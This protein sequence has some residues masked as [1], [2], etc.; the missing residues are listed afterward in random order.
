M[1]TQKTAPEGQNN[2]HGDGA[3]ANSDKELSHNRY[4]QR[5]GRK[6]RDTRERIV[7]A[8]ASLIDD[9]EAGA[10][11]LSAVA[12]EAGVGMTSIYN[13]FRDFTE[14][15]LALL[16]PVTVSAEEGHLKKLRESWP[17]DELD[18]HCIEFVR[19]YYEFWRKH[20]RLL[21]LRNSLADVQD[22]RMM[23]QRVATATP[24]IMLLRRQ[25]G[26]QSDDRG[27]PA[28]SMATSLYIGLERA[29]TVATDYELEKAFPSEFV[30][31]VES[32]ISSQSRLFALAIRDQRR[33]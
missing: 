23:K 21:H 32:L 28:L 33:A 20:A 26:D 16:E 10:I 1:S 11:T 19:S 5:I 22:V 4:G 30:L 7:A 6:G 18:R 17:D 27:T 3:V 31:K 24:A 2:V 14:L 9:P 29:F 25:M 12:R 13:Y 8:A 15:L